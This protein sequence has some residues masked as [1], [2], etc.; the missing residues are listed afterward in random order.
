MSI[1]SR[2]MASLN[3]DKKKVE[4]WPP[5]VNNFTGNSIFSV[6]REFDELPTRE[7]IVMDYLRLGLITKEQAV[8]ILITGNTGNN[9]NLF[10]DKELK[11]LANLNQKYTSYSCREIR[12]DS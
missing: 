8:Q 5:A 11:T 10:N 4:S 3:G 12:G 7:Q 2:L 6:S 1:I 9:R